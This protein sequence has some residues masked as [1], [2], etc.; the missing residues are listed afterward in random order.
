MPVQ[1]DTVKATYRDGVLQ[2]KLPK[3][4]EVKPREIKINIL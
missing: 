2:V 4:E 3:A 1:S